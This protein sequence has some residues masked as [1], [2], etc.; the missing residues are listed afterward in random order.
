MYLSGPRGQNTK[1]IVSVSSNTPEE[2]Q[3]GSKESSGKLV[4]KFGSWSA[5]KFLGAV[6]DTW[7]AQD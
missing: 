1:I 5:F 4:Q 3:N 6:A 7:G 2:A